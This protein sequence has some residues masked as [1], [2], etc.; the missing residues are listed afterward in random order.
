MSHGFPLLVI[1]WSQPTF[2]VKTLTEVDGISWAVTSERYFLLA[3]RRL[4]GG[5][6]FVLWLL[7]CVCLFVF[8][9]LGGCCR[10]CCFLW[11]VFLI[12]AE[13]PAWA[14]SA[15][16][17]WRP[18]FL[19]F[20]ALRLSRRALFCRLRPSDVRGRFFFSS[21]CCPIAAATGGVEEGRASTSG[22]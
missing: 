20:K 14:S 15:E 13:G 6:A 8:F 16:T 9:R 3:L 11:C 2:R 18:L 5:V 1:G 7:L 22:C 21:S 19:A 4:G 17:A 12:G 10:A